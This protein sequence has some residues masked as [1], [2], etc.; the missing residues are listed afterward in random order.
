MT[1]ALRM[2]WVG[3]SVFSIS[4][5]AGAHTIGLSSGEYRVAGDG[6]EVTLVLARGEAIP[7][8][9]ALDPNRDGSID[10]GELALAGADLERAIIGGIH[11]VAGTVSCPGRLAGAS[12]TE[13]DGLRLE[14]RYRCTGPAER[15]T[16]HLA[17]LEELSHGHRHAAHVVSGSS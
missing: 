14:A 17:F 13:Q 1:R 15:W 10:A 7:A 3:F 8:V 2:I 12:L 5:A 9:P 11:V 16:V 6:L 4:V